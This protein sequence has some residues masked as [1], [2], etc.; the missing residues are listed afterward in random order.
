LHFETT[1][2]EGAGIV[3][4]ALEE[5]V[6]EE[7]VVVEESENQQEQMM[8]HEDAVSEGGESNDNGEGDDDAAMNAECDDND[9]NSIVEADIG[10]GET[11]DQVDADDDEE[12]EEQPDKPAQE[13]PQ[14]KNN[15][16]T[17]EPPAVVNPTQ[18]QVIMQVKKQKGEQQQKD[19]TGRIGTNEEDELRRNMPQPGQLLVKLRELNLVSSGCK[20]VPT[21]Q[22]LL[23]RPV[24]QAGIPPT[25]S[26]AVQPPIKKKSSREEGNIVPSQ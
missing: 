11:S 12:E 15:Y 3:P 19:R 23:R 10:L 9:D 18:Q 17:M 5:V 20:F 6:V 16:R 4:V 7:V 8:D 2:N 24:Q 26:I 25:K 13:Y 22:H 21:P 14:Y 1:R